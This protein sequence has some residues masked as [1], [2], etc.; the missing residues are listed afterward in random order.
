MMNEARLLG[1]DGLEL[2][3]PGSRELWSG[4]E[5][6]VTRRW[7]RIPSLDLAAWQRHAADR[8]TLTSASTSAR[9]EARRKVREALEVAQPLQAGWILL[10]FGTSGLPP[11][12]EP[13]W[14]EVQEGRPY[15]RAYCDAKWRAVRERE[16]LGEQVLPHLRQALDEL[17]PE[18]EKAGV[19]LALR[20]SARYE[21]FPSEREIL[22]LLAAYPTPRLGCW[23]DFGR[24]QSKAHLGFLDHETWLRE[25][26]PRL[27]GGHVNDVAWGGEEP[28]LIPFQGLVPFDRLAPLLPPGLP[29]VWR[30]QSRR[31]SSDIKAAL[32][33]WRERFEG[34]KLP[35]AT[36]Q[37]TSSQQA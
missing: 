21:D 26:A 35:E 17:L 12:T 28:G 30:L 14:R 36:P 11:V 2:A 8:P 29:L 19:G 1:F 7:I 6:F 20:T 18:A 25:V 16:T 34:R 4:L 15:S 3:H 27:V 23:H 31:K 9:A 10:D 22:A 33:R 5:N 24:V 13:L 37:D 32:E